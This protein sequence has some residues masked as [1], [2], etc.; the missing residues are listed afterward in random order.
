VQEQSEDLINAL[1]R[2]DARG[3]EIQEQRHC[4]R[5]ATSPGQ[6]ALATDRHP[7]DRL[8]CNFDVNLESFSRIIQSITERVETLKASIDYGMDP[9]EHEDHH[10]LRSELDDLL[11]DLQSDWAD[12]VEADVRLRDEL[13]EDA[14]L[15]V[16]LQ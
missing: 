5:E 15:V 8:V 13:K 1:H 4:R 16:L 9:G 2:C 11:D 3:K 12:L 14:W 6:D 10:L 7:L